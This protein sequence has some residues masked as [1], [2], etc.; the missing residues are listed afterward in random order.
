MNEEPRVLHVATDRAGRVW[1]VLEREGGS[2]SVYYTKDGSAA[3]WVVYDSLDAGQAE[4]RAEQRGAEAER[5]RIREK[6]EAM[7]DNDDISPAQA[8][9]LRRML[10]ALD[11]PPARAGEG[12]N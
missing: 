5:Q 9:K 10:Y 11:T 4:I 6:I 8:V 3:H 2:I 1:R 7:A 12:E